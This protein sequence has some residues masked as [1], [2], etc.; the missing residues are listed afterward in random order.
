M[1][2]GAVDV[3]LLREVEQF[4]YRE[5]R[6]ADEH[7]YAGWEAL[8]TDDAVYWVP[9]GDTTDPMTQM[10]IIHDNRSRIRIRIRQLET[11]RRHAQAP[12]SQLRRMVTNIEL[13]GE[14]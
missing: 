3:E 8:W 14:H 5:A 10:S 11:G 9:S 7:D 13:L 4:I 12:P 2:M 1:S 6:L